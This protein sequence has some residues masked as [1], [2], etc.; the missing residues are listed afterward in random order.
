MEMGQEFR[1]TRILDE[2]KKKRVE[3][4]GNI[5]KLDGTEWN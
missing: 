4:N 2:N 1:I 5:Q 3:I